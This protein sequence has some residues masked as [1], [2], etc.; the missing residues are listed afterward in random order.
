MKSYF[1]CYILTNTALLN[2]S[3][4][5]KSAKIFA[6]KSYGHLKSMNKLILNQ[7]ATMIANRTDVLQKL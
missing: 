6:P 5:H 1:K 2:R 4:Y 7:P 3:T